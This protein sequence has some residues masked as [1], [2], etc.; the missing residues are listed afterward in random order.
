MTFLAPSALLGTLLLAIPIIVHLFKPRKMRRTPFS[1]LRWLKQTHQRLSRRIHW[2]QWLLFL[3][4]AGCIVLLV[5]ALAKPLAGLHGDR[6]PTDRL[7][8]L[9]VGRAM[10]Y[11]AGG[12][13]TPL[14]RARSLAGDLIAKAQPGDR[15]ALLLVGARTNIAAPLAADPT[16][17]LAAL[18]TARAQA[19]DSTPSS[20]LT[21]VRSLIAQ[22]DAERDMELVF[23]TANRQQSWQQSD[24]HAFL[25]KLPGPP[26]VQVVDLGPGGV[27]NA[28]IAG[29]R[30]LEPAG[31]DYRLLRVEGGCVGDARQERSVRLAGLRGLG[32]DAQPVTLSPGQLAHV[33]FKLPAALALAGQVAEL[34]LEPADAL[35]SDDHYFL[36]LDTPWA[37]RVLVVEPEPAR[38]DVPGVGRYLRTG[39]EA[40][41]AAGKGA[42]EL[43][44]R[45]ARGVAAGDFQRA[46]VIFLA[47]VPALS[48]AAVE[49]L[50]ARVRAGAGLVVFLGPGLSTAF[51][52]HK[53]YKA[54][55]P[56]EGLLPAPL[57]AEPVR[58]GEPVRLSGVRWSHSVLAPL[59]D[60]LLGDL[61]LCGF[62]R[63]AAFASGP[64][65]GAAVLARLDDE[66]AL[67]E[68]PLGAGRVLVWNTTADDAWGDL[69]ASRSFVPL[70]DRMLGYLSAGG[71][72]RHFTTGQLIT[73]PL[74]DWAPGDEVTVITPG[75]ER[76]APRLQGVGGKMFLHLEDVTEPGVYR[77]ERPGKA[78][79]DFAFAVNVGRDGSALAPMDGKTLEEWWQPA[80]LELLSADAAAER[81]AAESG[82]WPLWPTLVLGACLLLVAETV[83]VHRLCPRLN[84]AVA[85]SVVPQRGLLNPLSEKAT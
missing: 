50:E 10:S 80:A 84:P 54:L 25:E 57:K 33:D 63:Y 9:D 34:R 48:D 22:G 35:Q 58:H 7:V 77:V 24:L 72:R 30:V 60:P 73:L 28:W 82:G 59:Q 66:P 8:I 43:V 21:I 13:P 83:Y 85:A 64:E 3:L 20:A 74:A 38:P 70:L 4:R 75:G 31:A 71:V 18:R 2:H 67:I 44:S 62:R 40:L 49:G 46:D 14:E 37:L 29:A 27:Q 1:S 53:L 55:Q 52:N 65:A 39:V 32:E 69:A 6:R 16:A 36:N 61:A 17:A 26:R 11:E 15:T 81:F 68:R 78:G 45:T 41:A 23:L 76:L 47:G 42:L 51:Y 12:L 19:V 79:S 5:L 56:A